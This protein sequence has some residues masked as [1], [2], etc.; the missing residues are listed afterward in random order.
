MFITLWYC[1]WISV[2]ACERSEDTEE[3]MSSLLSFLIHLD[4]FPPLPTLRFRSLILRSS[5][6]SWI[7]PSSLWCWKIQY[8]WIVSYLK[9]QGG[10]IFLIFHLLN[11]KYFHYYKKGH[12]AH[13][14][15]TYFLLKISNSKIFNSY[16]LVLI[17]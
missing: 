3:T 9:H 4:S 17:I 5:S 10:N 15:F 2:R 8:Q 6:E 14:Y 1:A 12:L 11:G 7:F 16:S 13:G